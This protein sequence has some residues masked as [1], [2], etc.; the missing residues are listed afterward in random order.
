MTL[1]LTCLFSN[2]LWPFPAPSNFCTGFQRGGYLRFIMSFEPCPS[3]D[4][5]TSNYLWKQLKGHTFLC[6]G[7][8]PI[9]LLSVMHRSTK[10][11]SLEVQHATWEVGRLCCGFLGHGR[12]STHASKWMITL[13][14][15]G[16]IKV[17][18]MLTVTLLPPL[19]ILFSAPA[20][21]PLLP[22]RYNPPVVYSMWAEG[23]NPFDWLNFHSSTKGKNAFLQK[24]N[25]CWGDKHP[26]YIG[27]IS[28]EGD[29]VLHS[30]TQHGDL[31]QR[32][33]EFSISLKWSKQIWDEECRMW[34]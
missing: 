29:P 31:D 17:M 27:F 9:S 15:A 10:E 28:T 7:C 24:I 14:A 20:V 23:Q 21:D 34:Q 32:V 25:D 26:T 5:N 3:V 6:R 16:P 30:A 19:L 4:L 13:R 22:S 8:L 2:I 1:V 11:L 18:D 33:H 12:S